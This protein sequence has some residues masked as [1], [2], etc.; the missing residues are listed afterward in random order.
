MYMKEPREEA[1]VAPV[2]LS[3]GVGLAVSVLLTLYLGILPGRVLD[4]ADEGA[5]QM[6]HP[7]E[8][9]VGQVSPQMSVPVR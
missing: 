4:Y 8:Q 1:P 7:A 9:A 5:Q 3:L 2:S 6:L